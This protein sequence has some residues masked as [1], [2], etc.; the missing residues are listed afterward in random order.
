MIDFCSP[1]PLYEMTN[2]RG[3]NIKTDRI[4]FSFYFSSNK[5]VPSEVIAVSHGI[6]VKIVWNRDRMGRL[7]ESNT[8]ILELF[9]DYKYAGCRV[10]ERE[11]DVARNFFMKYKVLFSAVWERVLETDSLERYLEGLIS[12]EKVIRQLSIMHKANISEILKELHQL[13]KDGLYASCPDDERNLKI[14]E[15]IVRRENLFN[16]ND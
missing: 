1:E 12:F 16:M 7:D 15:D 13:K 8:G 6:S 2:V 3:S 5:S 9:G 4:N 11:L 10:S 14:F